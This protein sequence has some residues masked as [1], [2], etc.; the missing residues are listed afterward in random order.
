[1]KA[2][3]TRG[4][5]A[6]VVGNG[7]DI[8]DSGAVRSI[9]SNAHT[10]DWSGNAWYAGKIYSGGQSQDDEEAVEVALKTDIV[11]PDFSQYDQ[12]KPDYIKNRTHGI[13]GYENILEQ[14]VYNG[15]VDMG[16]MYGL[17][18]NEAPEIDEDTILNVYWDGQTFNDIAVIAEDI[19]GVNVFTFGNFGPMGGPDTG[20]PFVIKVENN[21]T[22][23]VSFD[24][25]ES[26]TIEIDKQIVKTLDKRFLPPSD[27]F[28][29]FCKK[30]F[31]LKEY[32]S[33]NNYNLF[34]LTYGEEQEI[35]FS[36]DEFEILWNLIESNK[37]M[38]ILDSSIMFAQSSSLDN[39]KQIYMCR[40]VIA[41]SI[42][43]DGTEQIAINDY[44]Y[45]IR[46][47]TDGNKITKQTIDIS[48]T[49]TN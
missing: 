32:N 9:R 33:K 41:G 20:E 21:M 46:Y 15:F 42:E 24:D 31:D 38:F 23:I 18:L 25:L 28:E 49:I 7:V 29:V 26:H 47:Y 16:G 30:V 34:Q 17:V 40:K 39:Y 5:Y 2:S 45:Y 11:Q 3:K 12:A 35:D 27:E 43:N 37:Y 36:V 14:K 8:V 19:N 1:M 4:K 10:L 22:M 6:F 44:K 13:I 48:K